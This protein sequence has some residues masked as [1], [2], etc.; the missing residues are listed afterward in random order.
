[1]AEIRKGFS[2]GSLVSILGLIAIVSYLVWQSTTKTDQTSYSKGATH[3]ENVTNY[4]VSPVQN[5]YP[6]SIPGCSPFVRMDTP[7]GIK[8][9]EAEKKVKK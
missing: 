9:P 7:G 2:W 5:L 1:M 3:T 4:T 8:Y 6:L